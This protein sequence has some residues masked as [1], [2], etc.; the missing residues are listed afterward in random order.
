MWT[1]IPFNINVE[2]QDRQQ[3]LSIQACPCSSDTL[4]QPAA[5]AVPESAS[6]S[7]MKSYNPAHAL[8]WAATKDNQIRPQPCSSFPQHRLVM[9]GTSLGQLGSDQGVPSLPGLT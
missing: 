3:T 7:Q 2:K 4:L 8:P 6:D 1:N 9:R 5:A